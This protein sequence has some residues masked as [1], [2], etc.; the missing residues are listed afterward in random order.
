MNTVIGAVAIKRPSRAAVVLLFVLIL[1]VHVKRPETAIDYEENRNQ[2]SRHL[3][4]IHEGIRPGIGKE[5]TGVSSQ[6]A[7]LVPFAHS[8]HHINREWGNRPSW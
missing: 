4:G 6:G 2:E 8:Y 1:K 7:F 3:T 5:K